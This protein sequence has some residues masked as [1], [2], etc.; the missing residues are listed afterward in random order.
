[1]KN[2]LL[3]LYR[4]D[5]TKKVLAS[6]ISIFAGLVLG[7]I[8]AVIVGL[9]GN[10]QSFSTQSIFDGIRLIFGG[11]FSTGRGAQGQLTFGFNP[12]N[13]G[14]MFF[15]AVPIMMTGLSVAVAFKTGL[16]NIGT[17]G[18]FL[19]GTMGTLYVALSVPTTVV[20]AWLVWLLAFLAGTL[21][22][23]I[24]GAIPGLLKA[25]RGVNEVLACIMTN[26]IAGNLVY[27]FF[28]ANTQLQCPPETG[29]TGY[30]MVTAENGVA[31]SK[32][33]LDK[34]LP[35]SQVNGG[36]IIAIVIAI[37]VY[38]LMNKTTLGYQLKACGANRHA[39]RY[40]GIKD[41]RN[42]VLSMAIAGALAAGGASLY[43]LSGNAEFAWTKI[44]QSLPEEGFNGIPV[45]LLATNHPIGVIFSSIFMSMLNINGQMLQNLTSYNKHL[46]DIIIAAIVYLSSFSLLIK[47]LLSKKKKEKAA[48][49]PEADK[50]EA[51]EEPAQA[52][53]E[54]EIAAVPEEIAGDSK[55]AE[56]G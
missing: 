3:D 21:L 12:S 32:M 50:A 15:R 23:A 22:G 27:M 53:E 38:V 18:Q 2:T 7:S 11:L 55:E 35:G 42:I 51:K 25:T 44:Y 6:L 30:I 29:K 49:S 43:F 28:K 9:T 39:A 20:P 47:M 26:W 8:I 40:A 4:K 16:F 46:S 1:M 37:G 13:W 34:L 10:A 52:A 33:G 41:K 36:I 48:P 5:G 56:E 31:T 14:N 24:W 17:P 19:M 54:Q 45:A